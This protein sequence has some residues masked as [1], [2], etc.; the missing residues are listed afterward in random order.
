MAK[1][2]NI[3]C[4]NCHGPNNSPLHA[5]GKIDAARVSLSADVCAACHGEPA[6][7]GR[8]QQW[9]ESGHANTELAVEEAA[10]ESRGATAAHCGRCQSSQ[11]FLAW[12]QQP[13]LTK[14]IQGAKGNATVAELTAMGL[15]RDQVL[16]QTCVT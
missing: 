5:N 13:D 6:R 7:H 3:Q 2:A 12:I 1:N 8:F 11:G 15:T 14:Y 16:P 9:E 4:E 10:V